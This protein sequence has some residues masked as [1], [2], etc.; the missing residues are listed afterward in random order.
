MRAIGWSMGAGVGIAL[1]AAV[2]IVAQPG[3]PGP[4]GM[5]MQP[6]TRA[7]ADAAVVK[8]FAR[9][10][11]NHDGAITRGEIVD[12]R[13][14]R[15]RERR[16]AHRDREFSTLDTNRDGAL[17]RGEFDTPPGPPLP[18]VAA[19]GA[20]GAAPPAPNGDHGPGGWRGPMGG[21]G[22]F[23][24]F[25]ERMFDQADA[26]RDGKVTLAEARTAALA[27][28]DHVDANHDGTLSPD[29]QRAA[30]EVLFGGRGRHGGGGPDGMGRH[31]RRPG[32]PGGDMPPLPQPQG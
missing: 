1:L 23:A 12:A 32:G 13:E 26:N 22:M 4:R 19:T 9:M 20:A 7:E 2:P 14:A 18:P 27:L 24:M 6:V 21:G 16:R 25:G 29:E 8:A 5:A 30:R 28:F 11:L 31:G 3:G 17:S 15:M 10:D